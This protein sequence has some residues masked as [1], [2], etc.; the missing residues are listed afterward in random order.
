M[1][2][3]VRK[4]EERDIPWLFFQFKEFSR[5]YGTKKQL[6]GDDEEYNLA[7][8]R[9]MMQE[10]LFLVAEKDSKL[11]GFVSGFINGHPYNKHILVLTET[12]WWVEKSSRGSKAAVL[13]LNEFVKF[14]KANVDWVYF[15]FNKHT[16]VKDQ[17]LTKRGFHM[18]ETA[19]MLEVS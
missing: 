16:G 17:H 5:F 14:G 1:T 10:H 19:Y 18:K 6:F 13:L 2:I 3:V 8:I 11:V 9:I 7:A 4:A 12:F 15:T